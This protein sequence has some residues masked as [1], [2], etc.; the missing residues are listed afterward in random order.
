MK[1]TQIRLA[2]K[3]DLPA[4]INLWAYCF[5]DGDIFQNWYFQKYYR[6]EE[7][8]VAAVDGTVVAS[9]QVIDLPTVVGDKHLQ[10]GYIVGVDCLPEYRGQGL[11]KRLMEEVIEHFAVQKGYDLLYLMPFE[12]DFYEPFGFVYGNYHAKMCLSIDE[13]YRAAY[14]ESAQDYYWKTVDLNDYNK[15][16]PLIEELY[17]SSMQNVEGYVVRETVR[18]WSALLDDVRMEN[19]YCKIIYNENDRPEGYLVYLLDGGAMTVRELQARN[20]SARQAIYYFIASHRSQVKEVH[21]SAPLY[22]P[23]VYARK[24][25]KQGVMLEPFMM[26]LVIDPECISAFASC[27]PDEDLNF[28]VQEDGNF[29]WQAHTYKIQR[30]KNKVANT[31]YFTRASLSQFVF[32]YGDWEFAEGNEEKRQMRALFKEKKQIFNNEYF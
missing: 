11:T 22:E 32:G 4:L 14:R 30:T 20:M 31:L 5:N 15:A 9:L 18:R 1:Q 2:T 3:D 16:L 10:A 19:G 7:C 26:Q 13:F 24:K 6:Q 21:W 17:V 28:S 27:L 25:D 29:C 12:A 23:V 8:L